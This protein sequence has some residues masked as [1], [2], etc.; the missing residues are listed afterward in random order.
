MLG[1][2]RKSGKLLQETDNLYVFQKAPAFVAR[3]VRQ[4]RRRI[5]L[6]YLSAVRDDFQ[7]LLRTASIIAGL[8]PEVVAMQEFERVRLTVE[9]AWRYQLIRL[10]LRVGLAPFPQLDGLSDLVSGLSVRMETAMKELGERAALA[11][12]LASSLDGRGHRRC[13]VA[14]HP[15]RQ[16]THLALK[17]FCRTDGRHRYFFLAPLPWWRDGAHPDHPAVQ[18]RLLL[19]QPPF[20]AVS[21]RSIGNLQVRDDQ[22][23][24]LLSQATPALRATS[25]AVCNSMIAPPQDRSD[26]LQ[27][28][29]V[30]IHKQ[31][32]PFPSA[33]QS[34]CT[35][36]EERQSRTRLERQFDGE[37]RAARW[38]IP[39]A[40]CSAVFGDN[41]VA[42]AQAQPSS[43]ADGF[44]GVEGIEDAGSVLHA[45]TAVS[46]LDEQPVAVRSGANPQVAIG[47]VFQDGIH[48]VVHQIQKDL[49]QAGKDLL[50]LPVDPAARSRWT[51]M[52]LMRRS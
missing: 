4:E 41:S 42:D 9:F 26:G 29:I 25:L 23:E 21:V 37:R 1:T 24:I 19:R 7:S 36:R 47:G 32:S 18:S 40:N 34:A 49:L 50:R 48:R 38:D 2:C 13:L 27:H 14:A 3:R 10:Q 30:L 6:A 46:K 11:A 35:G 20:Q 8:S 51:R 16:A 17:G 52:L 43:F 44:R 5:A 12:E 22:V 28:G 15:L 45:W 31:N 33:R 39:H